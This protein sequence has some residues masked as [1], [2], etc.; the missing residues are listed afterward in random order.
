MK[1]A[2]VHRVGRCLAVT[3]LA[4]V[5]VSCGGGSSDPPTPLPSSLTLSAP[6]TRQALN[7]DIAFA[8]NAVDAASKLTYRWD[9]GDGSTSALAAPGHRYA[10]SGVFTVRLT[11]S[12]EAAASVQASTTVAVAD[13]ALTQGKLCSSADSGGWCWQNPL[14]QGNGISGIAWADDRI[15]WAVGEVGTILKTTDGGA[16]WT[17]QASGTESLLL[18]VASVDANVVWVAGARGLVLKST[19][20][21]SN[22][23]SYSVGGDLGVSKIGAADANAAWITGFNLSLT[24]SDGG[25]SWRRIEAPSFGE[26]VQSGPTI[27]WAIDYGQAPAAVQ[28]SNDG[29][30]TWSTVAGLPS[31]EAGFNRSIQGL[32]FAGEQQ[33]LF[34]V[35]DSG[36]DSQSQYVTRITTSITS[37]AGA[38][39]FSVTP[40]LTPNGVVPEYKIAPDGAIFLRDF[41]GVFSS[42][43][44]GATWSALALPP[45]SVTGGDEVQPFSR[46]R[47]ALRRYDGTRSFT[48][49][50]GASW[51]TIEAGGVLRNPIRALWFFDSREGV[52]IVDFGGVLRTSDGG[53]NWAFDAQATP[54]VFGESRFQFTT[55]ATVGWMLA[56]NLGNILRSTD[57]GRTWLAPVQSIGFKLAGVR[58]FHFVDE[59]F[60]WAI[61]AFPFAGQGTVFVSTNGGMSWQSLQNTST[62][63]GMVSLRFADRSHGVAVGT[64][65]VAWIT[66]DGG[67]TWRARP[68]GSD[69]AMARVTFADAQVAVAVG[70]GGTILRSIDRGENWSRIKSPT[71]Q[72]LTDVRFVS[73][74]VGY[75]VGWRGTIVVT[76]D[77]G[78]TWFDVSARAATTLLGAF[79]ID[80]NTGWVFGENGAIL[81][82]VV[83]GR[84]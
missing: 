27:L 50:A 10:K 36:L 40:R 9:F 51:K 16:T 34:S 29:G 62:M 81:N 53:L 43:D 54:Q 33:G 71:A 2:S 24:T 80:E 28:R 63:T 32:Q 55:N 72:S 41:V 8:S 77:G 21:G 58:D 65:G 6:A 67:A 37:D 70:D 7:S 3:A 68:T 39:W 83:G 75:A 47:I 66:S 57:K 84:P 12:N 20:G 15:G 11:V 69:L 56:P 79:F 49:N 30:T 76:R 22:W 13:L 1:W 52:A 17:S 64:P 73:S 18:S 74:A 25:N 48:S 14:P 4:I 38:S 82:T 46:T 5:L 78:L 31:L 35:V 23:R 60:G 45:T 61:T 42:T 26:M 44:R 59:T 19:D